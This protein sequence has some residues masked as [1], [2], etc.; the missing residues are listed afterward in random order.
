MLSLNEIH[1]V[2]S[3]Q[4]FRP[5]LVVIPKPGAWTT[6]TSALKK[7]SSFALKKK[8]MIFNPPSSWEF[9]EWQ[10]KHEPKSPQAYWPPAHQAPWQARL[11]N[12]ADQGESPHIKASRRTR[13]RCSSPSRRDPGSGFACENFARYRVDY[14]GFGLGALQGLDVF[15]RAFFITDSGGG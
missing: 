12:F 9:N 4:A 14:Q 11:Y 1:L 5:F 3:W 13:Y 8:G 15:R 6:F 10:L 2:I 7:P